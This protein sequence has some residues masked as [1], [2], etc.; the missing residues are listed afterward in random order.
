[1]DVEGNGILAAEKEL[2]SGVKVLEL[3]IGVEVIEE[4]CTSLD[5]L[6]VFGI[7]NS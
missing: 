1:M 2:L 7:N 3:S 4:L 5:D 6:K